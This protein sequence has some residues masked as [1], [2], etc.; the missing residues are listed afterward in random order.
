MNRHLR[1]LGALFA[2]ALLGGSVTAAAQ[3]RKEV[4]EDRK[5]LR[6]DRQER[7]EDRKELR[8]DKK[9]GA[10]KEEIREDRKEL[11]ED[12]KEAREDRREIREDRKDARK[13]RQRELKEKWGTTINMPAAK[14]ELK[15]HGRRVARLQRARAVANKLGKKELAARIDKLLE[16]E[17]S[18]HQA[19]MDK[20]KEGGGKP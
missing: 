4:R 16:K 20:I 5:E 18:R 2:V 9:E 13:A 17:K 3:A 14:E 6:E 15:T 7:R 12:R 8:E 11:R 10:S 19:S 1:A